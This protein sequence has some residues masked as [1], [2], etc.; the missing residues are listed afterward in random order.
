MKETMKACNLHGVNDPKSDLLELP[1]RALLSAA[2]VQASRK[3][4]MYPL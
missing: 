2:P 3:N 1:Q 4:A